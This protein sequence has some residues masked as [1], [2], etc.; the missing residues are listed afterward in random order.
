MP[1][2]LAGF[3]V[4]D[5]TRLYPGPYATL[6]LAD[7]GAEIVK[8]EDVAEGDLLRGLP[9]QF[10]ALNRGKR[11]I[12]IDL[13]AREGPGVLRRLCARAD[14][15]IEGFRPGVLERPG[16]SPAAPAA[17]VPPPPLWPLARLRPARP[18]P[19]QAGAG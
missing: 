9:E 10:E 8:V 2:P 12:A 6:L 16:G 4:V 1:G 18:P 11:S 7:L 17:G 13:K 15:L 19:G 14:V 5:L 3:R